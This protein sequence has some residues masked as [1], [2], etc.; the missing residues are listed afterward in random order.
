VFIAVPL[1]RHAV[2]PPILFPVAMNLGIDPIHFGMLIK[3]N[4]EGV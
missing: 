4:M 1:C 2:H 3:V